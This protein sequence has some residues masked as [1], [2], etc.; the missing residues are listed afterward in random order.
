MTISSKFGPSECRDSQR[1]FVD[2]G[3]G[4]SD[5]RTAFTFLFLFVFIYFFASQFLE[6]ANDSETRFAS[7][8]SALH[9]LASFCRPDALPSFRRVSKRELG[10]GSRHLAG[11]GAGCGSGDTPLARRMG[12][13]LT[14]TP[15][16]SVT[17]INPLIFDT[18]N[19]GNMIFGWETSYG[20]PAK[21]EGI[22]ANCAGCIV[23]N[24]A[25][26][27][28]TPRPLSPARHMKSL[29]PWA[30]VDTA[31]PGPI[32]F[33]RIVAQGPGNGGPPSSTIEWLGAYG[34]KGRIA[35]IRGRYGYAE[36]R[37]LCWLG[38]ATSR[39]LQARC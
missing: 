30:S 21:P 8:S 5:N 7:P 2:N 26:S 37:H 22:Q 25:T 28:A 23:T 6:I 1:K 10:L 32:P 36:L 20:F 4:R 14:G 29:P 38:D 12:F 3:Q 31:L 35:Q 19:P 39:S 15:L 13:R 34:G 33:L 16:V 17:N 9:C 27:A 11:L 18:N 24:L